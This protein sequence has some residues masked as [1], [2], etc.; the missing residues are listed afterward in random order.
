MKQLYSGL[1][2]EVEDPSTS[3]VA[4]LTSFAGT[5]PMGKEDIPLILRRVIVTQSVKFQSYLQV[6]LW[7]DVRIQVMLRFQLPHIDTDVPAKGLGG[8]GD[9]FRLPHE[10]RTKDG[11][12]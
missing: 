9:Y 12:Q 1:L 3:F 8:L 7:L 10:G 11:A 6:G 5:W 4:R 2:R